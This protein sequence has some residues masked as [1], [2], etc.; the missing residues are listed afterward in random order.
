MKPLI[1]ALLLAL[2]TGVQVWAGPGGAGQA[3]PASVQP[4]AAPA[5]GQSRERP[6]WQVGVGA[7][8]GIPV[9]EFADNVDSAGGLSGH[10]DVALG[11][12]IVSL[13]A[14]GSYLLYGTESRRVPLSPTIPDIVVTVDTENSVALVHGRVRVQSREGRLRPYVDGLLGFSYLATRTSI[15]ESTDCDP[16]GCSN[17]GSTNLDDFTPSLGGGAGLQV[18]FGAPPHAWKLD[19]SVRYLAGGEADYLREGAIHREGGG[20]FFDISRSRTDMVLVYIGVAFGR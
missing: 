13:G 8:V 4:Q 12:S 7:I 17:L 18:G 20:A 19:L 5:Q 11:D 14:E 3:V 2:L 10:F 9:G 1:V 16:W 6:R 15:D